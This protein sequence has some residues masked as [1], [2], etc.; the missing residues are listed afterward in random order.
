MTTSLFTG[1][2]KLNKADK[3]FKK[4][5]IIMHPEQGVLIVQNT[6]FVMSFDSFEDFRHNVEYNNVKTIGDINL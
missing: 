2:V 5:I 4:V 3:E 6:L 1:N